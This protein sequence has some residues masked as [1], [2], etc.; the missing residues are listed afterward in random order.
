[1]LNTMEQFCRF[2]LQNA[3]SMG[4]SQSKKVIVTP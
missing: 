3:S 1:M 4:R 2:Y